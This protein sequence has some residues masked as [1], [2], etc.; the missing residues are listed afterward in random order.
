MPIYHLSRFTPI[1]IGCSLSKCSLTSISWFVWLPLV[2]QSVFHTPCPESSEIINESGEFFPTV[3]R[4]SCH[5]WRGNKR[6]LF[7]IMTMILFFLLWGFT[8]ILTAVVLTKDK[9]VTGKKKNL[10]SSV[11]WTTMIYGFTKE[12]NGY[13][14]CSIKKRIYMNLPSTWWNFVIFLGV[15]FSHTEKND[16]YSWHVKILC[17]EILWTVL[18]RDNLCDVSVLIKHNLRGALLWR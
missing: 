3:K 14:L 17:K 18:L 12:L 5:V 10:I 7:C 15:F 13:V 16:T 1:S 11:H 9:S 2:M 6:L 8:L 4:L